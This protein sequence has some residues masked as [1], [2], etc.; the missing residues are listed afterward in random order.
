MES[1]WPRCGTVKTES[2]HHGFIY[3]TLWKMGY[4]LRRCSFCNRK[5][6]F[7]RP[8]PN[9]PHPDNLTMEDLQRSFDRKVA[10]S[11]GKPV[12]VSTRHRESSASN[13]TEG[14]DRH[15]SHAGTSSNRVA[16]AMDEVRENGV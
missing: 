8:D 6:I 1:P 13:S 14:V 10:Q 12:E 16:V 9:R 2:V 15:R 11:L 4:H 3:A 7:K 5:R